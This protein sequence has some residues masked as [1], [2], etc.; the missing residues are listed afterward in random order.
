MTDGK[1]PFYYGPP[2]SS[3]EESDKPLSGGYGGYWPPG[4]PDP[5]P[6]GSGP[7]STTRSLP[8]D[9]PW[10]P[11]TTN[12]P[13]DPGSSVIT[14][15]VG[16]PPAVWLGAALVLGV[17]GAVVALLFG[18][19]VGIALA[20]W[21]LAGP[22]A[23]GLLAVFSRLDLRQ[24]AR[25]LY[26]APTWTTALHTAAILAAAAGIGISAWRIAEWAGQL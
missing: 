17:V 19:T 23:I 11:P 7:G 18:A 6:R 22:V 12:A 20:S 26:T 8:H 21:A 10:Q 9:T 1:D 15:T 13:P 16:Q 4:D 14:E 24:R 3:P 5:T 2:S 25:P